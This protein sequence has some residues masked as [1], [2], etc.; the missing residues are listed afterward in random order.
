MFAHGVGV[1]D[2]WSHVQLNVSGG[3]LNS[4]SAAFTLAALTHRT[5][6]RIYTAHFSRAVRVAMCPESTLMR[7]FVLRQGLL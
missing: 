2:M 5:V 1:T 4:D 6:F 7:S 3:D